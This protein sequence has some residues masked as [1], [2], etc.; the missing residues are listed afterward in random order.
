ML[1]N[2]KAKWSEA[3]Q[4][5][6]N[7]ETKKFPQANELPWASNILSQGNRV[8]YVLRKKPSEKKALRKIN[9]KRKKGKKKE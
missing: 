9:M 6:F 7:T 4:I 2:G 1:Y 8:Q 3:K 5:A